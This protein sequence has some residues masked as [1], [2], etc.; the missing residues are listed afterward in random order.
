M[1]ELATDFVFAR[2]DGWLFW[3]GVSTIVASF[4]AVVAIVIAERARTSAVAE[5]RQERQ[6][7][8]QMTTLMRLID[9][10]RAQLDVPGRPDRLRA[11]MRTLPAEWFPE[12][13]RIV[14][15]DDNRIPDGSGGY[16]NVDAN[17]GEI[18][19]EL[20]G[21]LLDLAKDPGFA[22]SAEKPKWIAKITGSG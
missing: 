6:A 12:S 11:L 3:T 19:R 16:K 22:E 17:R 2:S 15:I 8:W 10:N 9:L 18:E 4:L 5:S 1:R 13:R 21:A 20:V 7:Q 14:G